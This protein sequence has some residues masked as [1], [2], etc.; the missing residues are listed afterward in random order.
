METQEKLTDHDVRLAT[1]EAHLEHVSSSLDR[2][3]E[4]MVTQHHLLTEFTRLDTNSKHSVQRIHDRI[5]R[6]E[7]CV[8]NMRDDCDRFKKSMSP[9]LF[10]ANNPKAGFMMLIGLYVMTFKEVRDAVFHTLGG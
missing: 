1:I 6:M 4:T 9:L 2:L 8:K 10:F 7:E 3:A 5:D